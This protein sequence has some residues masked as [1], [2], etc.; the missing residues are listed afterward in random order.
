[1]I[2]PL[3]FALA[4]LLP[5]A[6]AASAQ[7]A[8]ERDPL[9]YVLEDDDSR[10]YLFGSIHL[11]DAAS[12]PL[13]DDVEAA[14]ADAEALAFEIDMSDLATIQQAVMARAQYADGRTLQEALGEERFAQLDS[15]SSMLGLPGAALT[16]YEPWAV[17]LTLAGLGVQALGYN[18]QNGVDVH[19][20]TRAR[21]DAKPILALETADEQTAIFDEMPE[22][23]QI[24]WLAE[25]LDEWDEQAATFERLIA[26]WRSGD[27][28]ALAAL[29]NDMPADVRP[30]L[31][32]DRN[33]RWVPQIEGMLAGDDD[34]LV[35]VGAGHLVGEGSVVEMLRAKGYTLTRQ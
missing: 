30:A 10:V 13:P 23:A 17:Q 34:V 24:A 11:L 35:I 33:A 26:A 29:L 7:T 5:L 27:A 6:P 12:Y 3:A 2:R 8:D 25:M 9:L 32:H 18:A 4:A 15:L 19:F 20:T 31:L 16:S 1:M 22:T 28:E 14:Y 21:A